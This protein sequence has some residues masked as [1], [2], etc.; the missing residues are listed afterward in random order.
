MKVYRDHHNELPLG[1]SKIYRR[2]CF[3]KIKPI[4][5]VKGWDFIDNMKK[6]RFIMIPNYS[7]AS[8]RVFTEALALDLPVLMNKN[9]ENISYLTS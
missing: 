7:D 9:I 3:E 6:S 2:S 8:P 4:E 5:A 1:A